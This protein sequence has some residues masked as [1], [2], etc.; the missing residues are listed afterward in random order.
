[1]HPPN[2]GGRDGLGL[3]LL[4]T[5]AFSA[6]FYG[7]ILRAGSLEAGG[8]AMVAGLMWCPGLAALVTVGVRHKSLRGLGWGHGPWR[9]WLWGYGSPLLYAGVVYFLVWW[10]GLGGIDHEVAQRLT[11]SKLL[12]LLPLG[13]VIG[14]LMAL[15][16]EIGWRG[17]LVPRLV[18]RLG[19][20]RGSLATGLIWAVWHYPLLLW[21]G[22][23]GGTPW[24]YSLLCFT[25][26]VV[27]ISFLFT[28]LR[29]A[30][31][32]VWPAM[33]LHASHNLYIQGFF[34]RLTTDTGPA[35]WW[36]G[37]FGA[38]LALAAVVVALVAWSLQRRTVATV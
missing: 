16:E 34:D 5:F 10:S 4:L 12:K 6:V 37:E 14:C 7:L 19:F 35:E 8:Q 21:G 22:Y 2:E 38:G 30:S 13:T 28:W 1:M 31:G 11:A 9:Y 25:V 23:K 20:V 29:L 27:G 32:S 15:G 36:I 33:L 26:M 3:F 24:P 18:A 17:F